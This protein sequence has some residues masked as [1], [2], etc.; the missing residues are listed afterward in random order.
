M[1]T[2]GHTGA[3]LTSIKLPIVIRAEINLVLVVVTALGLLSRL[4]GINFPKAVV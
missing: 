3:M 2:T 4:Y 1:L